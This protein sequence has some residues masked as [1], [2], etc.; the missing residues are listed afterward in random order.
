MPFTS[1]LV[2]FSGFPLARDDGA[3]VTR[4]AIPEWS[5]A[6]THSLPSVFGIFG[7]C[8]FSPAAC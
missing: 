3:G 5:A 1:Q 7:T 6:F 4:D 2:K 8:L